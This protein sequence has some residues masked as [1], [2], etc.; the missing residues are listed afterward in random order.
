MSMLRFD[1]R[2]AVI[3]GAGT[4]IGAA[5]AQQLSSR[6]ANVVVN[7]LDLGA[8]DQ[9]VANILKVGGRAVAVASDVST[10]DGAAAVIDAAISQFGRVDIVVNN[11]GM[12]RSA[13]F[14]DLSVDLLDRI[15]A[16]NLRGT[17]LITHAVW[18]LEGSVAVAKLPTLSHQLWG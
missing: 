7:D 1:D 2:V 17:F 8:A 15:I 5:Y 14:A 9:T 16:V 10:E 13:P 12:L 11:A 4:G 18:P 6:G 3:T